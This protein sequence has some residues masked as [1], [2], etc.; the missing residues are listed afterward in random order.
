MNLFILYKLFFFSLF[1]N[2]HST[3]REPK[4]TLYLLYP[5]LLLVDEDNFY[6]KE[7]KMDYFDFFLFHNFLHLH[8]S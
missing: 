6:E 2:T 8:L 4:N 3:Y 5:W 1:F 7:I